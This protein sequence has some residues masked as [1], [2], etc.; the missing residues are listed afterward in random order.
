[1]MTPQE[2]QAQMALGQ[3]MMAPPAAAMPQETPE[4]FLQRLQGWKMPGAGVVTPE[5]AALLRVGAQLMQPVA[6]KQAVAGNVGTAL[7]AGVD[8]FNRAQQQ[9]LGNALTMENAWQN[10][11]AGTERSAVT[12]E[13][14]AGARTSRGIQTAGAPSAFA[15]AQDT[16]EKAQIELRALRQQEASGVTGPDFLRRKAEAELRLKNAQAQMYEAH[17]KYY[18]QAA[19]ARGK[20]VLNVKEVENADGTKS[21]VT[22]TLINGKIYQRIMTPPKFSD[23]RQAQSQAEKDVDTD[24]PGV[25]GR[26]LGKQAPYQGLPADEVARRVKSYTA[27][28]VEIF[29]ENGMPV[30]PE[31]YEALEREGATPQEVPPKPGS[32]P[33]PPASPRE[34]KQERSGAAEKSLRIVMKEMA[35]AKAKGEDTSSF[36]READRLR[37]TIR[38]GGRGFN[39]VPAP[40]ATTPTPAT[41]STVRFVRDA[42]GKII[43]EGSRTRPAATPTTPTLQ[44]GP[45]EV[46]GQALDRARETFQQANKVLMSYGLRQQRADPQ[47]YRDALATVAAARQAMQQ[48]EQA[49]QSAVPPTSAVTSMPRRP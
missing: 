15:A 3:A 10:R 19:G 49:W 20:Q 32:T 4:E 7:T 12:A 11:Q 43:P 40:S 48:A 41:S 14:I 18:G 21:L 33:M 5:N 37:E 30:P 2:L 27:P 24:T 8:T 29:D 13:N 1:M 25:I 9:E 38:T 44:V 6:N 22:T 35:D 45:E 34:S 28:R 46:Q 17:G 23:P 31:Q 26:A 16:Y 39:E 36:Q 42:A 47:G